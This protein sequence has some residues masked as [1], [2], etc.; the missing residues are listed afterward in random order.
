MKKI[1]SAIAMLL[2]LV[3]NQVGAQSTLPDGAL[4]LI[5]ST[6]KQTVGYQARTMNFDISS[7]VDYTF[8]ADAD[9]LSVWKSANGI[10]VSVQTN[11]EAADRSATITLTSADGAIVRTIDIEQA[12]NSVAE[13][14]VPDDTDD[15]WNI[16]ADDMYTTLKEG[17]TAETLD[18]ITNEVVLSLANQI[19][20]GTYTT[21]YRVN[22]YECFNSPEY[23]SDIWNAPGKYYDH[24]EG[25]TGINLK[26]GKHLI[27]VR[28]IPSGRTVTL[29]VMGWY[30]GDGNGPS[31]Q[32]FTLNEGW[33]QINYTKTYDGLAYINY[34]VYGTCDQYNPIRVHFVNGEINGYLSPDKTNEEMDELLAIAPNTCMDVYGSR[35]HSVWTANGLSKY[36]KAQDGTSL[37]YRQYLNVLDTL[38]AWEQRLLGFEKYNTVPKNH[39]MAY[40]NYT[41]YMFQGWYGVSFINTQESRVLNC[42]TITKN[43]QDAIWGL[44][45]EWGHQHQMTPYFCWTGM[46]EITNNMNSYYNTTHMG[47]KNDGHGSM[48]SDGLVVYNDEAVAVGKVCEGRRNAYLNRSAY[49]WNDNLYALCEAMADSA[50]A[51]PDEDPLHAWDY[52]QTYRT[53]RT[54]IGLYQY[55]VSTLGYEDF[56]PDLYE[57]LRQNDNTNG[58]TIEKKSGV[59]KYELLASAQNNNKKS[60][61]SVFQKNY[62][63]SVWVTNNYVKSGQTY[64]ANAVPFIMNFIRK[65]SRLTGY[66]L[67]PYFEKCGHLR[68]IALRVND[69]G[70]KWY[71][72]TQDMYDEFKADMDALVTSGELKECDDDMVKAILT[73]AVP[74]ISTPDF[75]N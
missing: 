17:V 52:T 45:H 64:T 30:N 10:F 29:R 40:V 38:V 22:T 27:L 24:C 59:D 61:L 68:T 8:A 11:Y 35:T 4:P 7:N 62:P 56:G 66:N 16:F 28:D 33:N 46:S 5:L 60:K 67:F 44:S 2:M 55:A 19:L 70:N 37:G 32:T 53:L 20:A 75:P 23:L 15:D 9:W 63:T 65:C 69:Y 36:C 21:D 34:F 71:L 41:Y 1:L 49:E 39:T 51:D 74:S 31:E 26:P 12:A 6:H 57:S 48:P 18:T 43:D 14:G 58:S 50:C 25:V 72:M 73:Q 47:Y 13:E 54:F 3:P 42:K